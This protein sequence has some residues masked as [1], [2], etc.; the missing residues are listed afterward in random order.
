MF[1]C[2]DE[3]SIY[4]L[5]PH[6]QNIRFEFYRLYP[7]ID[8]NGSKCCQNHDQDADFDNNA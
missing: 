4:T 5:V 8:T 7:C 6:K 3:R 2:K 1:A